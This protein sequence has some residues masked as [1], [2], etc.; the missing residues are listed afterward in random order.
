MRSTVKHSPVTS[1]SFRVILSLLIAIFVF[2]S[3]KIFADQQES[4]KIYVVGED[5]SFS[6]QQLQAAGHD[7]TW[8]VDALQIKLADLSQFDQV[9]FVDIFAVPDATGRANLINFIKSGGKLFFVGD[10]YKE[11]RAPLYNWRDSLFNEL[12]AG[13][14]RQSADVNPSQ[15]VY[16]TNPFHVTSYTPNT[17]HYIEHGEGRNGSFDDIGNGTVIVGAGLDATGTP[18]AIAFNYGD[19]EEAPHSRAVIYLNSNMYTN[20]DLYVENLAKFL[21]SKDKTILQARYTSALP[22]NQGHLKIALHNSRDVSGLQFNLLDVPDAITPLQITT[23]DRCLTFSA[24]WED[25]PDGSISIVISSQQG[26]AILPG[27]GSIADILYEVNSGVKMGDSSDIKLSDVLISDEYDQPMLTTLL[28]GKFYCDVLKGD[29]IMDGVVNI[30]DLV[31]IIDIILDRPPEPT[32][33]EIDAADYNCDGDVN[34]LDVVAIIN[35]IL[36]REPAGLTKGLSLNIQSDDAVQV[37][38]AGIIPFFLSKEKPISGAQIELQFDP[39]IVKLGTPELTN[40]ADGMTLVTARRQNKLSIL[41]FGINGKLIA[42]GD[43]AIFNLP[44]A[45]KSARNTQNGFHVEKIILADGNAGSANFSDAEL[46]YF[47][48]QLLPIAYRLEQNYPNPF[49]MDTEIQYQLSERTAAN[50]TIFNVLGR[51]VVTLFDEEQIAGTHRIHWDGRDANG[52]I[53]GTGIYFYRLQ[54]PAFTQTR[55]MTILK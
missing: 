34:I 13:G 11:E 29:V 46:N 23:T 52:Q 5:R 33:I 41:I 6:G 50:L 2:S 8:E 10:S 36:G 51:K 28:N 16:Y 54:T 30:I 37:K 3:G 55:K 42:P 25:N 39:Q 18:I 21:G 27:T 38:S 24:S 49:N 26:A 53:V 48:L 7:V 19:L 22:E 12:G 40:R 1:I 4:F 9:W 15:T 20:W 44:F 32:Q 47:N 43:E 35:M 14:V 31:R 17:V 45:F